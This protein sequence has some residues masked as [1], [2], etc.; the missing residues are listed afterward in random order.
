MQAHRRNVINGLRY[1]RRSIYR[2]DVL[3]NVTF[4]I[5]LPPYIRN[6]VQEYLPI[7]ESQYFVPPRIAKI[8][9]LENTYSA[10]KKGDGIISSKI[11]ILEDIFKDD[12]RGLSLTS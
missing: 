10:G 6:K 9:R 7:C 3:T 2:A 12:T 8:Y 11:S 1:V 4:V 5:A